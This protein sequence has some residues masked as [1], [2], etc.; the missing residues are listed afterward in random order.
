MKKLLMAVFALCAVLGLAACGK[1]EAT[2]PTDTNTT[3]VVAEVEY[4]L[5]LGI[6]VSFEEAVK[7]GAPQVDATVAAVL[8][9]FEAV[10]ENAWLPVIEPAGV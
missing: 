2:E 4:K 5:G 10:P 1:T 3:P 7:N 8:D 9:V 6:E